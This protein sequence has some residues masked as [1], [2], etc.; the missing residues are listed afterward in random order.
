MLGLIF[1]VGSSEACLG[2]PEDWMEILFF[3]FAALG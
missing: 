2:F 3:F 1:R